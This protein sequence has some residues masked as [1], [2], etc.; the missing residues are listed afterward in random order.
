MN[1]DRAFHRGSL[2]GEERVD[3]IIRS[4]DISSNLN[5]AIRGC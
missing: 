3:A 2:G 1:G 4:F 5:K